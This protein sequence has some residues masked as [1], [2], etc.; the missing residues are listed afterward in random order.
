MSA[1]GRSPA[2]PGAV[3]LARFVDGAA[4]ADEARALA[5]HLPGCA[6]CRSTVAGLRSIAADLARD[7]VGRDLPDLAPLVLARA[8]MPPARRRVVRPLF[9]G[10]SLAAALCAGIVIERRA[11][12]IGDA[13]FQARGGGD[14]PDRWVAI[15]PHLLE[16]G[17]AVRIGDGASVGARPLLFSYDNGG[18]APYR[19]L[20]I[21]GSDAAGRL[22][23]YFP[24]DRPG[25]TSVEAEAGAGRELHEEVCL[26][27][28]PGALR[29]RGLF[30][31]RPLTVEEVGRAAA[32][33][34][35]GARLPIADTGQQLL[36]LEVPQAAGRCGD[37]G[38]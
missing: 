27:P 20:M 37:H 4:G 13:G 32:L 34:P 25:A 33:A 6:R 11:G 21:F 18:P 38:R 35:P 24:D 22:L 7:P 15:Q 23:W 16:G 26:T 19:Y 3:A 29:L 17:K 1:A 14:N 12:T 31:R 9:A 5:S 36:T 10:L 8:A 2:C 28:A 30:S